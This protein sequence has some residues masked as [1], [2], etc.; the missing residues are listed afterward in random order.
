MTAGVGVKRLMSC[1]TTSLTNSLWDIIFRDFIIRT[2]QAYTG[3]SRFISLRMVSTSH[4]THF[5]LMFPLLVH[6]FLCLSPFLVVLHFAYNRLDLDLGQGTCESSI[7]GEL[8]VGTNFAAL[9]MLRQYPELSASEGLQTSC[10]IVVWDLG[11]RFDILGKASQHCSARTVPPS[12]DSLG[13]LPEAPIL[14]HLRGS[15]T[16]RG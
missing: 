1:R 13:D 7:E 14:P 4:G 3:F 5:D 9:G 11:G 15:R 6:S 16:A 2:M 8:I 12:D 10:K